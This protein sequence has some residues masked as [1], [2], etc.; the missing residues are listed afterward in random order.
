MGASFT[1]PE[2]LPARASELESLPPRAAPP[3]LRAAQLSTG[4]TFRTRPEAH[5]G[6]F[7]AGCPWP[8]RGPVWGCPQGW[9]LPAASEEPEK[10]SHPGQVSVTPWLGARPPA[11]PA[12]PEPPNTPRSRTRKNPARESLCPPWLPCPQQ[13]S[14]NGHPAR[15]PCF[16]S[17]TS[18]S[19]EGLF[20][21]GPPGFQ[22][23][24]PE[25]PQRSPW[26]SLAVQ[27]EGCPRTASPRHPQL[28]A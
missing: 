3:L 20:R 15:A 28:L 16:P 7:R 4:P 8:D 19:G 2:G 6:V 13:P 14:R 21:Q 5:P 18:A 25:E 22:E 23:R 1:D 26:G 12:Q 11:L 10:T 9:L 27:K 17:H 24:G